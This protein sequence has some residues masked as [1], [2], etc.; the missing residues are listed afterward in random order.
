VQLCAGSFTLP[1]KEVIEM[2]DGLADLLRQ[3]SD[4]CIDPSL[5]GAHQSHARRQSSF[6]TP[7]RR[8][9]YEQARIRRT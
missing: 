8:L 3:I 6:D 9:T 7:S 4:V 1:G 2:D 5:M